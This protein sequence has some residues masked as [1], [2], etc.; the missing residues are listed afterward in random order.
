[1]T[2]IEGWKVV[3]A[4]H[5]SM[6][7]TMLSDIAV[8]L[9][10]DAFIIRTHSRCHWTPVKKLEGPYL[11]QLDEC[12]PRWIMVQGFQSNLSFNLNLNLKLSWK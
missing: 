2:S 12:T 8:Y 4:S 1:M 3:N 6:I 10:M 9:S 11:G 5:L 7:N